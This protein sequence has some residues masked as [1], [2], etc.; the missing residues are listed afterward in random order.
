MTRTEAQNLQREIDTA[1]KSI[2]S[3]YNLRMT[4]NNIR[5]GEREVKLSVGMEQLNADGTHK[6]DGGMENALRLEFHLSGIQNTPK[7]IIGSKVR[8]ISGKVFIITGYN[9]RAQKYP[10]EAQEASTGQMYKLQARGLQFV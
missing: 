9:R 4:S 1:L 7:T 8:S 2:L 5:F 6:V 10:I 3:K